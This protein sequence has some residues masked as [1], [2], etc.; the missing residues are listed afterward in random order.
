MSK[1]V[2]GDGTGRLSLPR[3]GPLNSGAVDAVVAGGLPTCVYM[4]ALASAPRLSNLR[5]FLT[6]TARIS[7]TMSP[8]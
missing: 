5:N 8:Y 4:E 2:L 1:Q 3:H 7:R 6:W